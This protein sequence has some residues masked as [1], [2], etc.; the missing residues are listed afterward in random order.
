MGPIKERLGFPDALVSMCEDGGYVVAVVDPVHKSGVQWRPLPVG[1]GRLPADWTATAT[2]AETEAM[3]FQAAM[4]GWAQFKKDGAEK[5]AAESV[6]GAEDGAKARPFWEFVAKQESPA[7]CD[8]AVWTL[9]HDARAGARMLAA[10]VLLNFH[11]RDVAWWSLVDG[12]RD[13]EDRVKSSCTQALQIFRRDHARTVDW[14]PA[15][16][17]L[18]TV[19]NGTNLGAVCPVARLLLAT[20]V[21]PELAAAIVGGAGEGLLVF[22][23]SA[24]DVFASPAHDLL[25]RLTAEDHKKDVARWRQCLATLGMPEAGDR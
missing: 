2:L 14:G 5:A 12:L 20:G 19:L 16:P 24:R 17:S 7:A 25:Q 4:I 3:G 13:A 23:P 6:L 10:A 21:R 8:L 11:Q 15:A 1:P 22:V 18:R 9:G